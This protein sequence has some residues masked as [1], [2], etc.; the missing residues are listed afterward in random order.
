M[1]LFACRSVVLYMFTSLSHHVLVESW[2][3]N[4]HR[5]LE[6]PT[7]ARAESALDSAR[8][9]KANHLQPRR[10]QE[11][12]RLQLESSERRLFLV[13]LIGSAAATAWP[14][15]SLAQITDETD[16]FADNWWSSK[17]QSATSART[18]TSSSSSTKEATA[19]PSDEVVIQFRQSDL[20]QSTNG[21]GLE[22]AD[23]EFRTNLRVY[24]KS[25]RPG[26]LASRLGIQKDWIVVSLNG[27]STERTNAKG[28]AQMLAS[29]VQ[30]Q[31]LSNGGDNND[32]TII[33]FVFRDP[34]VFR[35]QLSNLASTE[36]K[37]ATTQVAPAGDTSQR[38][39]DGSLRRPGQGER[40]QAD[41]KITVSQLI[42]P[43]RCNR[44]ATTDDLLEISY[45]G[46]VVETGQV[47]DGSAIKINGQAIPGRGDDVTLFFVLGKQPFGQFPPGWDA[48]LYGMC[49]GERRRL[50]IPPVLA[51]GST[52]LPRRGIPPDATLQYDVTLVSINGLATPQ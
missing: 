52:G 41:Q 8:H 1:R 38:Y 4:H 32:D 16:N 40:S 12:Q 37:S 28:V 17:G 24:V 49:V 43:K 51:Y 21:L 42:P 35:S 2:N 46:T 18:G 26:S 29:A 27:E 39:A 30:Q 31:Q 3:V 15:P 47:F 45:I 36:S 9:K 25:V 44:G 14:H 33:S 22:L 6:N 19:A 7:A 10:Q 13:N 23:V 20:L 50:L 5:P 48:G 11:Q 34:S